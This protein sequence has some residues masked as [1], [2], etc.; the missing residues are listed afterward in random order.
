MVLY[1]CKSCFRRYVFLDHDDQRSFAR[2]WI[3]HPIYGADHNPHRAT[4]VFIGNRPKT[5]LVLAL[6]NHSGDFSFYHHVA[7]SKHRHDIRP[8]HGVDRGSYWRWPEQGK[9]HICRDILLVSIL[10][11]FH[12]VD[13]PH[14]VSLVDSR[15]DPHGCFC[16]NVCQ[17]LH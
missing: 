11:Q 4:L 16:G 13:G 3:V 6:C 15:F 7:F 14:P 9:N 8:L 12:S 5:Q 1:F 10:D 2:T 17:S